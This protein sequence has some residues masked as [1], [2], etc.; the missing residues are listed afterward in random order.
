MSIKLYVEGGGDSK[1]LKAACRKGFRMFITKAGLQGSMPH[2]VACGSRENTY[3]DFVRKH[4]HATHEDKI[5]L[6]LVDAEGP[7]RKA[8]PWQ[9]LKTH[10]GWDGQVLIFLSNL[11]TVPRARLSC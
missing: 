10:E 3:K 6:L 9:H 8:G 11:R 5:A 4:E 1:T 7:V 2:I